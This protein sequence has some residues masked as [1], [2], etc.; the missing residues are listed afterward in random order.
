MKYF[1]FRL[2]FH[3]FKLNEGNGESMEMEKVIDVESYTFQKRGPYP[4]NAPNL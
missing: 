3:D 2:T 1:L 4:R